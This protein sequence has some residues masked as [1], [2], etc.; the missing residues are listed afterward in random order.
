[1][2][3]AT[4]AVAAVVGKQ[5]YDRAMSA[6]GSLEQAMPLASKAADQVIAG[7]SEG[8]KATAA[9]LSKLTADAR[10]QTSGDLWKGLEWVPVAGPNLQ[11]VRTAAAVS[12]DLVRDALTPATALSLDALKPKEARST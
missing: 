8:A 5:V 10:E 6:K 11:A 7:D 4:A 1:M 9:Q 12:D 3:I 2:L